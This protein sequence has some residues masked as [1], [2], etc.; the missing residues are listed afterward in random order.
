MNNLV[1]W[2]SRDMAL[3]AEAEECCRSNHS[4]SVGKHACFI[5]EKERSSDWHLNHIWYFS[6][7]VSLIPDKTKEINKKLINKEIR[8]W[9][10]QFNEETCFDSFTQRC[11]AVYTQGYS[12]YPPLG[13]GIYCKPKN[14][15]RYVSPSILS[16]TITKFPL[17]RCI[18]SGNIRAPVI[19]H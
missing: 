8:K 13:G 9:N 18:L 15:H 11:S 7:P 19:Y 6:A 16:K 17:R 3:N 5:P 4:Y 1:L 10:Q 12:V 2:R 14:N